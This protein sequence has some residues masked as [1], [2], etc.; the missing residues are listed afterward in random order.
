MRCVLLVDHRVGGHQL[1]RM[2][3]TPITVPRYFE[4]EQWPSRRSGNRSDHLDAS[5]S[6]ARN[7]YEYDQTA[8]TAWHA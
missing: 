4:V 6:E 2:A 3:P 8:R 1:D 7:L 5:Q